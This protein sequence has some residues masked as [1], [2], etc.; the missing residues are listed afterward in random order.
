VGD[1]AVV[2]VGATNVAGVVVASEVDGE[3]ASVPDFAV[4]TAVG[5]DVA[6]VV[7]IAAGTPA[8]LAAGSGAAAAPHAL[9]ARVS[10][11]TMT[12]EAQRFITVNLLTDVRL[13]P[14]TEMGM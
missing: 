9:N 11:I 2:G 6:V 5:V 1:S 8:L 13:P 3:D 10:K 4:A 14:S 12:I 7:S